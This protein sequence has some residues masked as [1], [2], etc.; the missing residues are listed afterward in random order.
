PEVLIRDHTL[1]SHVP[2]GHGRSKRVARLRLVS[3]PARR[4][5]TPCPL[6]IRGRLP[7]SLRDSGTVSRAFRYYAAIRLLSSCHHFV[8]SS[9][10]ATKPFGLGGRE[11]SLGK[12]MKLRTNAVSCTHTAIRP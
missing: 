7:S 2:C 3:C 10:A 1:Q 6:D 11:I 12:A 8:L 5:C 9:S 4:S